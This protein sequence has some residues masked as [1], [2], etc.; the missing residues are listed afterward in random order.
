[1]LSVSDFVLV[2][3]PQATYPFV[4]I[5]DHVVDLLTSSSDCSIL[6]PVIAEYHVKIHTT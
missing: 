5:P 1:M 3:W 2:A 4:R 6:R